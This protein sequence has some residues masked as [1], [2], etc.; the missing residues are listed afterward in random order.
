MSEEIQ[1]IRKIQELDPSRAPGYPDD[2]LVLF[3][4]EEC[5]HEGIWCRTEGVNIETHYVQMKL[6]N[7]PFGDF[8]KHR[9][10]RV[11][12]ALIRGK[13]GEVKAVALL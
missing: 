10:E 12:V 7:E 2:I 8:G 4:K 1:A 6:L 3:M 5:R 13:S 9:G 11:D